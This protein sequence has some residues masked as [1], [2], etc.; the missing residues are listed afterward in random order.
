MPSFH[1][2]AILLFI[3]L[4]AYNLTII[5]DL[6]VEAL[7][8]I[9]TFY[10]EPKSKYAYA[11]DNK[12]LHIRFRSGK[13]ELDNIE[14]I[15]YDPYSYV[16]MDNGEWSFDTS[17]QFFVEMKKEHSDDLFDY[18]FCEI[19][20]ID[21][22]RIRYGFI[23]NDVNKRVFYGTH[24]VCD[25]DRFETIRDNGLHF[26]SFPYINE[27]D[28]FKAPDWVKETVWY[29][30]FPERFNRSQESSQEKVLPW[31]VINI[32]DNSM[33]F[34][35]NIAGII[36][37]LDYLVNL[38]INGIYFTPLFESPSTHKYD[39]TDYFRIDSMFGDN[40]SMLKLVKEA[41]KRNIKVMLDGVFNHCGYYHPFWQ[42]VLEKGK[43]SMYYECFHIQGDEVFPRSEKEYMQLPM[44]ELMHKMNYQSFGNAPIMPKWNTKSEITRKHL[45]D[46]GMY[47]VTE[48]DIDGWRLDV[49]NEVS[50][51]FWREFRKVVKAI[52]PELYIIGENWDNSTPWLQGDQFDSVMNY[53]L[54]NII[55]NFIGERYVLFKTDVVGFQQCLGK[56]FVQ[57][58]KNV[59][60]YMFNMVDSH[61][62]ARV[63]SVVNGDINKAKLIYLIQFIMPGTPSIYYGS[64]IGLEG[65]QESARGCMVFDDY[66]TINPLYCHLRRLISLRRKYEIFR[67]SDYEVCM[68][69]QR[70]N[71]IALKKKNDAQEMIVLIN[72]SNKKQSYFIGD[73]MKRYELEAY[74]GAI[75]LNNEKII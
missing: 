43:N 10:H 67:Q 59:L 57:Y 37:K 54:L 74:E 38:G 9:Q 14:V 29:Q 28:V 4:E 71:S 55:W 45:L 75:Y 3:H 53:E 17:N 60:P 61:D 22:V 1:N 52:K 5:N 21:T 40:E 69:D 6:Q 34:G 36:E 16:Q 48:Y 56:Y 24:L 44:V 13:H 51:S 66:T 2:G 41:H 18:W 31:N 50:H 15:A 49:S 58:Q 23:L 62:T 20:E 70:K 33:T 25:M 42:D 68:L 72:N 65:V 39:T 7:M 63:M 26:F 11:Y 35:G 19:N 32:V 64:E 30:I 8:N 47:W 46:V 73:E 12:T 27:E